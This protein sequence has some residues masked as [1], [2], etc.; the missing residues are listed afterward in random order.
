VPGLFFS[1]QKQTPENPKAASIQ[2]LDSFD[3][4]VCGLQ[5]G[6]GILHLF[7]SSTLLRDPFRSPQDMESLAQILS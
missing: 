7:E 3:R 4:E 6:C 2:V 1:K 5:T